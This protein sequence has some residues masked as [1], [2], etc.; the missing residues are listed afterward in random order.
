MKY[1]QVRY[2]KLH[3]FFIQFIKILSS[4]FSAEKMCFESFEIEHMRKNVC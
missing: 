3:T 4:R 2:E 1:A